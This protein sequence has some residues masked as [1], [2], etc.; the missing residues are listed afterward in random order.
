MSVVLIGLAMLTIA[1]NH[2]TVK[3]N[4]TRSRSHINKRGVSMPSIANG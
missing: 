3:N 2:L 4:L 1:A